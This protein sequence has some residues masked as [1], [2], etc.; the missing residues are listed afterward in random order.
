[1]F[2]N[3]VFDIIDKEYQVKREW[4]NPV[5]PTEDNFNILIPL[6]YNYKRVIMERFDEILDPI[7]V[8]MG[9]ED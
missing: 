7:L 5:Y 4:S 8:L 9:Y 3:I 1:M 6:N 2:L